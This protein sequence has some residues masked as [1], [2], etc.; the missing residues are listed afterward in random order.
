MHDS[1]RNGKQQ[2]HGVVLRRL[3]IA[4]PHCL[5]NEEMNFIVNTLIPAR[6]FLS[7]GEHS[8][9]GDIAGAQILTGC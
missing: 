7:E 2:I 6:S 9:I 8:V 5:S 4:I 1:Q 3:D